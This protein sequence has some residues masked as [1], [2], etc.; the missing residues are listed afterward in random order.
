[1]KKGGILSHEIVVPA[2]DQLQRDPHSI[3][4]WIDYSSYDAER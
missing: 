2:L 1:M 3:C 4:D